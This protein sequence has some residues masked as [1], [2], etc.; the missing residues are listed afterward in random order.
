MESV[1]GTPV[2]EGTI[3]DSKQTYGGSCFDLTKGSS[4]RLGRFTTR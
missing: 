1:Y 4:T 3:S 2:D